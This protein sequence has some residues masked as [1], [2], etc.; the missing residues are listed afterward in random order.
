[1]SDKLLSRELRNH[2]T[3]S[4]FDIEHRI[5]QN[6]DE[7]QTLEMNVKKALFSHTE[8]SP[9][10]IITQ[11]NKYKYHDAIAPNK[12]HDY[13]AEIV[14]AM[15]S[16]N[17]QGLTNE[18]LG[19]VDQAGMSF[20]DALET[21]V[22]KI[23]QRLDGK[24]LIYVELGPEPVKTSFILK[25]LQEHGVKI[26]RYIAV[27]INPASE[28]PLRPIFERIL[29]E[30]PVDFVNASFEDF[31]LNEYLGT[32]NEPALITMLGFQEGNDD[33]HT[34]TDW[35]QHIA[36]SNDMLLS[37]VQLYSN[38]SA[39]NIS[40]FYRNPKMQRFSRIAFEKG[41]KDSAISVGRFYLLPV[42]TSDGEFIFAAILCEEF[43]DADRNRKLFVSNYCLK[44]DFP[45]YRA[46]REIN[47]HF[48]IV[49][50]TLTQDETLLFQISLRN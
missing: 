27:D 29:G 4:D 47:K 9:H 42:Q 34:I 33:P 12:S 50:E 36:R 24:G 48:K 10:Q 40:N 1:M 19:Q 7:N 44:F 14:D 18:S 26:V 35:L 28:A 5:D 43:L 21:S 37:E 16:L 41:V 15:A 30:A 22:E 38:A 20:K 17:M 6:V 32:T 3:A 45:Q 13:L 49:E 2:N 31:S 46:Y 11:S 25:K 8:F 23:A 39:L